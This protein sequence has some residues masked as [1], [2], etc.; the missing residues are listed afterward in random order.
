MNHF[1]N[2]VPFTVTLN[3]SVED[4]SIC[5]DQLLRNLPGKRLV[6]KGSWQQRS[7]IIKLF[8]DPNSS[9]RHWAREKTGIEALEKARVLTPEL[10]F[11]G[12]LTDGTPLLVFA[13]LPDAETALAVWHSLTN[14]EA[15][16]EL[17]ATVDDT[18]RQHAR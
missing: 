3:S 11:S 7:V 15:K 14:I 12:Q 1:A 5:C 18:G 13:Y 9:H 10:I 16:C 8:L 6:Y 17:V 2:T 4:N